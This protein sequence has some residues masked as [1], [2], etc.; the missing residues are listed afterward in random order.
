MLRKNNMKILLCS[1]PDGS[2]TGTTI[3]LKDYNPP[4]PTISPVGVL[5]LVDWMDT[6]GYKS[7]L[8]DINNLRPSDD[9]LTKTFKKIKP[10]VVGLSATLSHCYPNVKRITKLLRQFFPEVWIVVGGHITSS[11]NVIL[12]KTETDICVIGDGEIPWLELLNYFKFNDRHVLDYTKLGKIKGLAFLDQ[13]NK[14]KVT[15]N[16][17]QI[18]ASELKFIDYDKVRVALQD[19]GDMVYNLFYP[20]R[21]NKN[22]KETKYYDINIDKKIAGVNTSKGCVARCTF[23][24]RYT[25]GYRSYP[26]N[27]LEA[28]ILHLKKNYNVAGVIF[29]DENFGSNRK[30]SYEFARIMKKCGVFWSAFGVRCT[31]VTYEDLIFYKENNLIELKF[32]IE[33]GSQKILDIM[34]KKFTTDDIYRAISNCAK[35]GIIV[36]PDAL[37]MG[38]P[39]E[40]TSTVKE[41]A[42]FIASL[43]YI[44][45]LDWNIGG[46]FWAMAIPGTPLYEYCQQIGVIGKTID[47]EEEYLIRTAEEKTSFLNYINKT[48][49][50]IEEVHYWNFLFDYAGKK[51]YINLIIQND[52][53]IKNKILQIY[54]KCIK[55]ELTDFVKNLKYM[56]EGTHF[57]KNGNFVQKIKWFILIISN[58]ALGWFSLLLPKFILF[59]V[60]R[61]YA[62]LRFYAIKKKYKV[63]KGKQKYNLFVEINSNTY[64]KFKVTENRIAQ[65]TRQIERSLRNIVKVNRSYMKPAI[66]DEEKDLELLA[67]GQ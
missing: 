30:Q 34:E 42:K 10:T 29:S 23:C 49:S 32:G 50:S 65:T 17:D 52:S 31:S 46:P 54:E 28:Y 6:N 1:V 5:R 48:D 47:E 21:G 24:Q 8:Y 58:F 18:P 45:G 62:N 3:P 13:N 41:S 20:I 22:I 44:L 67:Q 55:G 15:G 27:D 7:E 61:F 14:L 26:T 25:K 64:D 2:L 36:E 4:L 35:L 9:E 33:S 53:S 12:S 38:M 40:T 66:T 19:K 16:P 11:A 56:Y 43:R 60:V 51:A 63:K 39:G 37:M 57:Y 59:P